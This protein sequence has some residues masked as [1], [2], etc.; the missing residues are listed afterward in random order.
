MG[1]VG[2]FQ[3]PV[4]WARFPAVPGSVIPFSFSTFAPGT[5]LQLQA[6]QGAGYPLEELRDQILFLLGGA[7]SWPTPPR[8]GSSGG[9]RGNK[10]RLSQAPHKHAEQQP[11]SRLCGPG[12]LPVMSTWLNFLEPFPPL[13]VESDLRKALVLGE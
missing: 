12:P 6:H 11:G 13:P 3:S 4:S 9:G 5:L 8:G 1:V 7:L 2:P 10:P